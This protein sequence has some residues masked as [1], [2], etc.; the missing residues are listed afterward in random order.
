MTRKK[1]IDESF[2]FIYLSIH[3]LTETGYVW[4]IDRRMDGWSLL[5]SNDYRKSAHNSVRVSNVCVLV[6]DCD[7]IPKLC[8]LLSTGTAKKPTQQRFDQMESS[9]C[10][11]YY[12]ILF[13][14]LS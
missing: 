11:Q 10:R 1:K 9:I 3:L 12:D 7:R 8:C 5:H 4:H 14:Q 2:S 6:C 13:K